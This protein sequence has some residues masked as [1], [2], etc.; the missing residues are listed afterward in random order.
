MFRSQP[1]AETKFIAPTNFRGARVKATN[2]TSGK[3]V[4]IPWDHDKD[5]G[6]NHEKAAR[7]V[8]ALSEGWIVTGELIACGTK[9]GYI[10]TVKP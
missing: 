9:K 7:K 1:F 5:S 3:S 4:T 2:I 10:F 8:L 6:E